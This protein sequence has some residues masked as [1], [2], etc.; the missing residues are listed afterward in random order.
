MG[1]RILLFAPGIALLAVVAA[2]GVDRGSYV[3]QNERILETLP[4]IP[5]AER[6]RV[7]SSPYYL[8]ESGPV[9]GYTTNVRYEAPLGMSARDVVDFYVQRL[10]EDW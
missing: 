3:Q 6:L 5:G 7:D 8:S 10:K 1:V 2:C 9:D 4:E